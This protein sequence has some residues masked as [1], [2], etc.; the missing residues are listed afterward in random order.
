MLG[1][2]MLFVLISFFFRRKMEI[3]RMKKKKVGEE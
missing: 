3:A 2:V 1:F